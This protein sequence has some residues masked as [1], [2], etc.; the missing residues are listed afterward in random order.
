MDDPVSL[1]PKNPFKS[2]PNC[3]PTVIVAGDAAAPPVAVTSKLQPSNMLPIADRFPVVEKSPAIPAVLTPVKSKELIFAHPENIRFMLTTPEAGVPANA[4][5][6]T[7]A[8]PDIISSATPPE[9]LPVKLARVSPVH[10]ASIRVLSAAASP[11]QVAGNVS[12]PEADPSPPI[13][14]EVKP[15]HPR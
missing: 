13:W 12:A 10:P 4:T 14:T 2:F 11:D 8:Q 9:T 15:A 7:F 6:P 5:D 3:A 1:A